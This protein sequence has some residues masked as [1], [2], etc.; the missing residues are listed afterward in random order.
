MMAKKT[1]SKRKGPLKR[2]RKRH[3]RIFKAARKKLPME[4]LSRK[5]KISCDFPSAIAARML[6][7]SSGVERMTGVEIT[8]RGVYQAAEDDEWLTTIVF[9]GPLCDT[10]RAHACMMLVYHEERALENAFNTFL[11]LRDRIRGP[12]TPVRL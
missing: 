2:K 11:D 7:H 9:K 5:H 4:V 8:S 10:Y 6:V 1:T 12:R 3:L